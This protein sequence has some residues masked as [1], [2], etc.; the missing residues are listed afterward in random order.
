MIPHFS[1]SF[2]LHLPPPIEPNIFPLLLL[3]LHLCRRYLNSTALNNDTASLLSFLLL[4]PRLPLRRS[5]FLA[6]SLALFVGVSMAA[7]AP[8][9][10]ATTSTYPSPSAWPSTATSP[11][12]PASSIGSPSSSAPPSLLTDQLRKWAID[13]QTNKQECLQLKGHADKLATLLCQ[14]ARTDLYECPTRRIMDEQVLSKALALMDKCRNRSFVHCLFSIT[15]AAAFAK[16]STQIDNSISD[17][18]WLLRVSAP[19]RSGAAAALVSLAR[20]NQ[21]FAKLIIEE[22][23]VVLLLCI[24]KEVE[25]GR[26][27]G[28]TPLVPSVSSGAI[29]RALTTLSTLTSTPP[30]PRSSRM[31]L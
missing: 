31:D 17:V 8:T 28:R 15:L 24:L 29:L 16:I 22:D 21:H 11:S 20:D 26:G 23:G 25:Q 12:S 27:A 2:L 6:H 10:S 13:A 7:K 30:L 14:T 3:H 4:R 1:L 18:S 5:C 19:A 9:S